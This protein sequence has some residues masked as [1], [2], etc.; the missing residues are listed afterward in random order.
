M[1]LKR[2][3]AEIMNITQINYNYTNNK[4]NSPPAFG[5]K[6][7]DFEPIISSLIKLEDSGDEFFK[8]IDKHSK[9]IEKIKYNKLNPQIHVE[10]DERNEDL[11]P[12]HFIVFSDLAEN[13][14]GDTIFKYSTRQTGEQN[15]RRF[16]NAIRKATKNMQQFKPFD[17]QA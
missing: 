6:L 12:F 13:I 5:A 3:L 9:K 16:I 4:N 15:G 8:Y 2:K 1:G 14:S 10:V 11:N 7:G 17:K